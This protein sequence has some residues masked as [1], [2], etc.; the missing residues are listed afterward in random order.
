VTGR[1]GASTDRTESTILGTF[2]FG[3]MDAADGGNEVTLAPE[4]DTTD[5]TH[6]DGGYHCPLRR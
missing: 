4:T 3:T 6:P 1:A 2:P 5:E